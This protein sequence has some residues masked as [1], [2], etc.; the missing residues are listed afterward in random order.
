MIAVTAV[1]LVAT[2]T[3][4]QAAPQVAAVRAAEPE[5]VAP[6]ELPPLVSADAEKLSAP[7]EAGQYEVPA[8]A[9]TPE[10]TPLE[11]KAPKRSFDEKSSK[12]VGRTES[13]TVYKNTD[14]TYTTALTAEPSNVLAADGTWQPVST[15]VGSSAD[16]GGR[17]TLHPLSP[18]FA[19]QGDSADLLQVAHGGAELSM[20]L[21]GAKAKALSR[22]GAFARY[23][24]VLPG[25]DLQ[26]EVTPGSV[27]E[28]VVLQ[29]APKKTQT[30]SWRI[31]GTGF[32]L[33]EGKSG[34]Y[35]L[36]GR[37][38]AV[39]MTI[40]PAVMVDSSGEEGKSEPSTV[41]TP[42]TITRDRDGW[43]LTVTPS[44][45]W[46]TD[47]ARVYPVS[48][49]PTVE[50]GVGPDLLYSYKS[51]GTVI[52]DARVRIGNSRDNNTDKYWRTVFHF[53]YEQFFGRQ[54]IDAW[55]HT[56][57]EAGTANGYVGQTGWASAFS[58]NSIGNSHGQAVVDDEGIFDA[59]AL[60]A[61]YAGWV[62]AGTSGV[63][64]YCSGHE[65]AGLYTYK[66]MR[67]ALYVTSAEYPSTTVT[68]PANGARVPVNPTLTGSFADPAASGAVARYFRVGTT[69]NPDASAVYNSGWLSQDSVTVPAG[70]LN[71]G[72]TY[73]WKSMVHNAYKGVY[74]RSTQRESAVWSFTTN[75]VPKVDKTK[76]TFD[77]LAPPASGTQTI[78]STSPA[79]TWPA[80]ASDGD[81]A[82]QYQVRIATG[83]DA[84]SGTV[85]TSGW[86]TGTSYQ[87]PEG[88]LRDGGVY[89]WTVETK[90]DLGSARILWT[91]S[92]TVNRRLAESG[93]SPVEQVGPVTVN[94]ANGNAGLRFSS[95][96]VNTV[97]GPM[98][99]AFSYNS[100]AA[101]TKGLLGRY[102]A[103]G[104]PA[105]SF[106]FA[107]AGEPL[108]TRTDPDLNFD[109]GV[110]A[111]APA[112]P[113]DNFAVRWSGYFTPPAAGDWTFGVV[114][115]NGVRVV[116]D[117]D[118]T[119]LDRWS[120]ENGGVN[121]GTARTLTGQTP[122]RVDYYEAGGG[123]RLQLWAKGPGY[124]NGLV[125]P[126]S[127][128]SPTFE[129]LPAGWSASAA[130]AGDAGEYASAAVE[131]NAVVVTDVTGTAHT[132]TKKSEG[133]YAAPAGEYGV[134]GLSASGQVNLTEEDGTVYVF[135]T[136]G[137]LESSTAPG[138]AKKPATPE[139]TWRGFTGQVQA[140][141]DRASGKQVRMFYGGDTAPEGSG[142]AC[143][144]T[145]GFAA[146][147][148]GMVCRI[149]YPPA[150]GTGVGDSTYL[151]YDAAGRLARIVDPGAEVTDFEYASSG[152]LTALRTPLISDWLAADTTR[153]PS[154]ANKLR[155]Q[156]DVTGA[157]TR[158]SKVTR[159]TL[160][161]ADGVSLAG[162]AVSGFGSDDQ[163]TVHGPASTTF[164]YA[165]ASTTYVDRTGISGHARTVTF[166][167]AWR[168]LTD[169]SPSGLRSSQVWDP[170]KDLVLSS[171]DPAGRTT[172]TIYDNRDRAVE[173]YGAAPATCFGSDRTPNTAC[174][175]ST[176]HT[177]TRYDEGLTGLN[178][179]Y[180][181]GP[182]LAGQ[183]K[184]IALGLGGG[185]LDRSWSTP[186]DAGLTEAWGAR[187]TGVITFPAAGTYTLT[188]A[189]D[190]SVQ[191]WV[192]D[193][194]QLAPPTAGTVSTSVIRTAAG[195]ARIR[196]DYVNTAGAGSLK[197]SWSGPGVASGAVPDTVL[198][199]DYGLVTSTTVADAVPA[200]VPAGTPAVTAAQVPAQVSQVGY[201]ASPWL[202]QPVTTTEDPGGLALTTA[203]T[204]EAAG[205][206]FLRRTGRFLPAATVAAV[207]AGRTVPTVADDGPRGTRYVYWGDKEALSAATCGVAAGTSQAGLLKSATEPTAADGTAIVTSFVYDTWGR[208]VGSK[209]GDAGWTC[210]VFD[211][212]GRVTSV[213]YPAVGSTPARTVTNAYTS[214]TG[215]PLTSTVSDPSVTGSPNGGTVTTVVDLLGRVVSYTD[216][217][218]VKTTTLYDA[219]GR[220]STTRTTDGVATYTG[221]ISY[222]GDSR[223]KSVS[224]GGKV[225]ATLTYTGADLTGVTYPAGTGNA[226]NGT[227]LAVGRHANGAMSSLGWS[228]VGSPALTDAVVRSQSGRIL[229][230]TV[231][232][233]TAMKSSS[234]GYDAAGR[235]VAATIPGHRLTYSFAGTSGCGLNPYAGRDGNRTGSTDTPT[236]G[237]A[238]TVT[239]CFDY[240]DRLTASTVTNPVTG[241]SPVSGTSLTAANLMYDGRG[242]TTTLADQTLVYD[243]ANR[244][245]S[246]TTGTGAT[247]T[248]L[249]DGTDR[250]VGRTAQDTSTTTVRYGFT[251]SGD[252]SDLVVD[253]SNKII[254][255]QLALPGG[256]VVTLP[257]SGAATWSYPNIHGDVIAT[258]DPAGARTGAVVTYDP[259]GQPLDPA[260][261]QIGTT[262]ADDSVADNMP[263]DADNAWVGQHQKLYEHA[264]TMAAVEM[265]AR[266]Y[267]PGLGRFLST[268][269]VEGGV[270]NCYAYPTDPINA[271]DL[272]G[273]KTTKAAWYRRAWR[274]TV[275]GGRFIANVNNGSTTL[276]LVIARASGAKCNW[277]K[278]EWMYA[279]T[280]AKRFGVKGG[281]T[282]GSTFVSS[283]L[284]KDL[285]VR[286]MAH[287][288]KHSNQWALLGSPGM[289]FGYLNAYASQGECNFYERQAGFA[290]GH[291][292]NCH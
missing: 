233:G 281:T 2:G 119:V 35:E 52:S 285:D 56:V 6:E 82:V 32:G 176:A 188:A 112:V 185:S 25:A 180:Y 203:T 152:E 97:G 18:R 4:G 232:D 199:P 133:G 205:A 193:I 101:R 114:Q 75:T 162:S 140:I 122:I 108:M 274:G 99:L 61:A 197:V 118:K 170:A 71:E 200:T 151:R 103:A 220:A 139:V 7:V 217:W 74:G 252:S 264:G 215:D 95:P 93:P 284:S 230:D 21:V 269:P 20:S 145:S 146:P 1:A 280:G 51:D 160:P 222:D 38:G 105:S 29:E 78:V 79:I 69:P 117:T 147:P 153:T 137:R 265:G 96:T 70:L 246:T 9:P 221:V 198:S 171:S 163:V 81:G 238:T 149:V 41:N 28:S 34:S 172:T 44:Q 106:A 86:Q 73:Y 11:R 58:F 59:D 210:S 111:P 267:L 257:T 271:F 224:D 166:D 262:T 47:P 22:K 16:G 8:P 92:F 275:K 5:S 120:D 156:Y 289:A 10:A 159:I 248:Y 189:S 90:D 3:V 48:I 173:S 123:A 26:Y 239:S 259:F 168:Q 85:L 177:S 209:R 157:S 110:G 292:T 24:D 201:G 104:S 291:Y 46:L 174:A 15:S 113:A 67:V 141:T 283:K 57:V 268:D 288:G 60:G 83:S 125:V 186:P 102:Y 175:A 94:L 240:A 36:V 179:A 131:T 270:D 279:C 17:I 161:A 194:R 278:Q 260:T 254:Q 243:A 237:T 219:A 129:T 196:I 261:G 135:G 132:Y 218:N 37:D 100:Q 287:E 45:E 225:V 204:Y 251:G 27:K 263:T 183:P 169:S 121:W 128:L 167:G 115:D 130:L 23:A 211:A 256:V 50:S 116:L 273:L 234:Y 127:W 184:A 134:L 236:G 62:N 208:A 126:S 39:A 43:L 98:G 19:A 214:S 165:D 87:V 242:N 245:V 89:T 202:G 84:V 206:G 207:T 158:S 72:T 231:T 154:D 30:Y 164:T 53:N 290:D 227:G 216:V 65:M 142:A 40:P 286:V 250:I 178:V 91:A 182:R 109:W 155:I 226:G 235:L 195:P 76:V 12:I 144:V 187:L 49:D 143:P 241:A 181:T 107:S 54:V 68:S 138:D 14:G 190:D 258:A 77:G 229:T 255:R 266:V 276:G 88:S 253:T 80:V 282:Y 223:L 272:D 191:V 42:M 124:P 212:R 13:S 64:V 277:N 136:N 150:S 63:Y 55:M 249:R 213:T 244:H 33:R 192:D 148:A 66:Y 228:F 31:R 247:V